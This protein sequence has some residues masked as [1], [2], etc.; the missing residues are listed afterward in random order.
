MTIERSFNKM[1]SITV[2]PF[3]WVGSEQKFEFIG[4]TIFSDMK[5]NQAYKKNNLLI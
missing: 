4:I 3:F 1:E 2:L 5:K